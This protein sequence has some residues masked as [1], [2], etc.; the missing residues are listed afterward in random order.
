MHIYRCMVCMPSFLPSTQ[1]I[2]EVLQKFRLFILQ[3]KKALEGRT[4]LFTINPNLNVTSP[5]PI[6]NCSHS[7]S[8]RNTMYL[9]SCAGLMHA[10]ALCVQKPGRISL[11]LRLHGFAQMPP[12]LRSLL[13]HKPCDSLL[14]FPKHFMLTDIIGR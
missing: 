3:S 12:S 5:P 11:L 9:H 2:S 8:S 13:P 6:A 10:V 7:G 4:A 1:P 14:T